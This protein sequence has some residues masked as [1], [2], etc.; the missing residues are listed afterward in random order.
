MIFSN[1]LVHR[2]CAQEAKNL[3]R[4]AGFRNFHLQKPRN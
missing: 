2:K 4:Y 1:T 3:A